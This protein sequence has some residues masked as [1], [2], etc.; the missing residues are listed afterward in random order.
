VRG[1]TKMPKMRVKITRT[2]EF[3]VTPDMYPGA[4]SIEDMCRMEKDQA[5]R[6]PEIYFD[7]SLAWDV[8]EDTVE[9][10]Y[11]VMC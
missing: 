9:A 11:N 6:E 4:K 7:G 5:D 10:T 8:L 1:K 3:D 2:V